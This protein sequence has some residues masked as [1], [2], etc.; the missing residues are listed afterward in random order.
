MGIEVGDTSRAVQY[1]QRSALVDLTDNQ[2]NTAEGMHIAS[3]GG[4]WQILVNGFGGPAHPRRPPHPQP[5]AARRLGGDPVPPPLARP[6]HQGRGRPR[7]HR[8]AAGRAGRR[9]RGCCGERQ[10]GATDVRHIRRSR[11][12]GINTGRRI[13]RLI[14]ESTAPIDIPFEK[15]IRRPSASRPA[16]R[17]KE[18][19]GGHVHPDQ[20]ERHG[21][22]DHRLRRSPHRTS[23][24]RRNGQIARRRARATTPSTVPRPQPTPTSARS[25]AGTPTASPRASSRS[26]ARSTRWPPTTAPNHLHGGMKGFDKVVWKAEPTPDDPEGPGRAA[27]LHQPRRRG[28]L[29]RQPRRHGHLHADHDDDSEIDYEATTDK[30]T[31][32]NLTNHSYFNLAGEASGDIVIDHELDTERRPLHRR[33]TRRSSRPA[34][35]RPV[36]GTPFDFTSVDADRRAHRARSAA[37][38]PA[39]TTTSSSTARRAS[40][41]SP[42]ACTTPT[43]GG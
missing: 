8:T 29:P 39:T 5:L 3:A 41:G 12:A 27:H 37:T 13:N 15:Y 19:A 22:Q 16:G 38:R 28:R 7:T 23:R 18:R 34:R 25:S 17:R 31:L 4:T 36:K 43:A 11:P 10:A 6:P 32:V 21:R 14:S 2:G 33:S 30:P 26:T 1:F 24:P 9:D 42:P 20:P 40:C 35:S